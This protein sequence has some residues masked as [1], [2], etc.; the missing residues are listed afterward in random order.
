MQPKYTII[1]PYYNAAKFIMETVVCIEAQ[2]EGD[3]EC[4]LVNNR[5][6]DDAP[7]KLAKHFAETK[8]ARFILLSE[9]K[10][11]AAAARN[12]GLRAARGEFVTFVDADDWP[13][14]DY[15]RGLGKAFAAG[16]SIALSICGYCTRYDETYTTDSPEEAPPLR[17]TDEMLCR[18]FETKYYQGYLWNKMYRTAVIRQANL[19]FDEDIVFNE[20]RLFLVKYL[21]A[22]DAQMKP[23]TDWDKAAATEAAGAKE[24]AGVL[25]RCIPDH[26]YT[27]V[28]H[29][30]SVM[31]AF[32]E[33]WQVREE[34]TTEFEA[35]LRMLSV[36]PKTSP[37]YAKAEHD[38]ILSELRM[39]RRMV[40]PKQIFAYT[41]S[42]FRRYAKD[43]VRRAYAASND[44][45]ALLFGLLKRYALTGCTYT[46]NPEFFE[47]VG[48]M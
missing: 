39:F 14:P 17:T 45:E 28:L 4:L 32:R 38:M 19:S 35:F 22:A 46:R 8:D 18:L 7:A 16:E 30:D 21:L 24:A 44:R 23:V 13:A 5:S 47:K 3:F 40:G 10:K 26:L 31:G 11:G 42:S 27:Y 6:T 33:G 12:C 20:D 43:A 9:E 25:T 15:L 2:T 1:I 29:K 41:H 37:A 36:L 48:Q 34:E